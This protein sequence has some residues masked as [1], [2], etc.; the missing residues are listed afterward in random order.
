[1]KKLLFLFPALL[2]IMISASL[3]HARPAGKSPAGTNAKLKDEWPSIREYPHFPYMIKNPGPEYADSL[4]MFQ[5]IPSVVV[6]PGGRIWVTWYGGGYGEGP[7]NYVMLSGSDDEGLTW[8]DFEMVIDPPYRASEPALWLDPDG[9][10]WFMWNLYPLHLRSR[11]T[12]LWV[13]TTENPDA[14]SPDWS[15]PRLVAMEL[16]N[17]NKPTVLSDGTWLWPTGSWQAGVFPEH[18]SHIPPPLGTLSQPL[19]SR[20]KGETFFPG[21][22]IPMEPEHR[23]CE[24]YQVV[25]RKDGVLWLLTRTHREN[26]GNGI[27][28][29]FSYDGGMTWS[30]VSHTGI[31]HTQ[32]RFFF[33]RLQSGKILLVKNGPVGEDTGRSQMMAFLSDDD[34]ETWY[35]GLMLDERNNVS[36]PDGMQADDGR[37]YI[38]YD[39]SRHHEKEI[40]LAIFSEEDVAKGSLQSEGSKIKIIV[41]KATGFN[42]K[43]Q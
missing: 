22:L 26:F 36:Y 38:V 43:V 35:G 33:T 37:I 11:G 13:I 28:E 1:M 2:I 25:E 5:G 15:A 12:Q 14:A 39:Y 24:E 3:V 34:G 42:Y 8:S 4:R 19:L 41:N 23:Q 40:L 30:E 6:T 16:N 32:S 21:G 29:S 9:M 10:M 17:F 31:V 27:G 20:D 7:E 18:L